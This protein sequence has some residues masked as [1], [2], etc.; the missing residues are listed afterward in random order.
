MAKK[1]FK[2]ALVGST[3]VGK[4]SVIEYLKRKYRENPKVLFTKEGARAYFKANPKALNRGAWEVQSGIRDFVLGIEEEAHGKGAD[5]IVCDRSVVDA[6]VY[7]EVH[8]DNK[9]AQKMLES[10][11]SWLPTYNHIILLDLEGIPYKVDK[12]RNESEEFRN[13][14]H[15]TFID[16]LKRNK[17]KYQL[18]GGS[19]KERIKFVDDLITSR[20]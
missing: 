18:L 17:I 9:S 3:C 14:V 1:A 4:T 20:G 8:G 7:L 10:V 2:I 13:R 11:K 16:F 19:L 5:V 15:N 6:T 12:I